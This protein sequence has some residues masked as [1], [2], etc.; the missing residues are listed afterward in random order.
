MAAAG[1]ALSGLTLSDVPDPALPSPRWLR[2]EVIACGLCG[3]DLGAI[4]YKASP[5]LTPWSSFPCV[6]G[7]EI[8]G[9]VVEVGP[10]ARRARVGER[11]A[12]DPFLGCAVREMPPCASCRA[13]APALCDR[14][15]EGPLQG[16]LLG[17]TSA[18]PGGF[19]ERMVIHDS[20]VVPLPGDVPDDVGA[21]VEP[22]SVGAHAVLRRPPREGERVLVIGGGAIA[23]TT[24]AA[25]RLLGFGGDVTVACRTAPQAAL[26]TAL[27][28]T[29]TFT[30]GGKALEEELAALLD[31]RLV[32]PL[33]GART[34]VGGFD[35]ALDCVGSADSLSLALRF[36][37]ARGAVTMVGAAGE[38][39]VDLSF[40]WVKEIALH[41]IL[42]NAIEAAPGCRT[43]ELVAQRAAS[44]PALSRIVT[45]RVALADHVAAVRRNLDRDRTGVVKTLFVPGATARGA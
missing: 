7:H 8:L 18:L 13:G 35:L 42:G 26:A 9:R 24:I 29:R 22:L 17:L 15:T 39:R 1:G 34:A 3:S 36:T 4:T 45:E 14:Q 10:E 44:M 25:I 43:L 37:R 28:A 21:L 27:G 11:V 40:L 23:F 2:I 31:T 5:V 20:Q 6:L 38:L 41:G 12:V 19:A 32:T 33:L 16:M 30:S